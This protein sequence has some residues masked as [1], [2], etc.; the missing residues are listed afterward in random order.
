M[1]IFY[2]YIF[3]PDHNLINF[4]PFFIIFSFRHVTVWTLVFLIETHLDAWDPLDCPRPG[5]PG[6]DLRDFVET[7]KTR[8]T[9]LRPERLGRDDRD[10]G[11]LA[12]TLE[13]WPRPTPGLP[14]RDPPGCP[15]PGL[16]SQDLRDLAETTETKET[17]PR[18]ERLGRDDR[19]GGS[20]AETTE[21]WETWPTADPY[22]R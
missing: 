1:L 11:S 12:E 9:W 16:P 18:P 5:L 13:N 14:N 3:T 8:E 17:C 10:R 2:F 4:T 7:T 19:D 20:L 21:T 6:Q 22:Y 15:R